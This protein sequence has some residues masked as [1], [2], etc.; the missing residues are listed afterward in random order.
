MNL[1]EYMDRNLE[2]ME[3]TLRRLHAVGTGWRPLVRLRLYQTYVLSLTSYAGG[4]FEF[5][6]R[7]KPAEGDGILARWDAHHLAATNWI[8]YG[9]SPDPEPRYRKITEAGSSSVSISLD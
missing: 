7:G 1:K 8:C 5:W 2:R 6:R 4:L 3:K 9:S